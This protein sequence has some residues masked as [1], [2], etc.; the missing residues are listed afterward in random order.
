MSIAPFEY[1]STTVKDVAA[2]SF[3]KT[4]AAHL[5]KGGKLEVP[6]WADYAKTASFKELGPMDP[7]W[8]YTRCGMF[9]RTCVS[10][11]GQ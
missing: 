4:Y 9:S 11:P 10:V 2:H 6:K 1:G 7:D 3:I 5:K 8:F